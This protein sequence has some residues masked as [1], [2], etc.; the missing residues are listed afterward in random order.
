MMYITYSVAVFLLLVSSISL[1]SASGSSVLRVK[2]QGD[3]LSSKYLLLLLLYPDPS[4][5]LSVINI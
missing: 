5:L 2:R 1:D 4:K 3:W